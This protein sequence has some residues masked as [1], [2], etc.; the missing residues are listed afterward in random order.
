MAMAIALTAIMHQTGFTQSE[1]ASIPKTEFFKQKQTAGKSSQTPEKRTGASVTPAVIEVY[2]QESD[3]HHQPAHKNG[4]K[5]A[6][7]SD[8]PKAVSGDKPHNKK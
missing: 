3:V 5:T 6:P 8:K 7:K 4:R 1:A 2:N